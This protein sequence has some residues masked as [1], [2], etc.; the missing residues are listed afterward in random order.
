[1]TRRL[2]VSGD[3][4]G[5]APE[6]NA[7]IVRAHRD[8]ILTATSL[9]VTGDAA[10]DAVA[11]AGTCPRLAVGL[12]L[13]LVQ[14]RPASPPARV[15]GLA[16]RAGAFRD[17]P[18]GTGLRSGPASSGP[19]GVSSHPVRARRRRSAPPGSP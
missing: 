19:R 11:R 18:I 1:M 4:F 7:A 3:D 10:A 14:G 8:G 6:V 13:V 12:H 15:P 17:A 2:V 16:P 5:S 9:M